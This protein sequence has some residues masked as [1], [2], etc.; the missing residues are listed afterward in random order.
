MEP[1]N[2]LLDEY[3]L[4]Q[5][6]KD[7]PEICFLPTASGDS[8]EYIAMFYNYFTT[9]RCRPVHLNLSD[10]PTSDLETYIM[11]KDII[12]V[13]GGHTGKMIAIWKHYHLDKILRKA[14]EQ[15][16]LLAGVSAG[17][18]CWFRE[19]LTD[20][21][22][23]A[24]MPEKCLGFL[25]GS[26]CAH[27]DN[28]GRKP[29]YHYLVKGQNILNGIGIDNFAAVHFED[30]AVKRVVSSRYGPSAHAVQKDNDHTRE[31]RFHAIYLGK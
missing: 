28:E 4:A 19:A 23:G 8:P 21:V 16:I 13:G 11:E 31:R 24:L 17:S 22:P 3:V 2:P 12:Y 9:Q 18:S 15:G 6:R 5:S 30:Q 7:N 1:G 25:K 20:S 14:W 26:S 10:P 29:R 27:Y